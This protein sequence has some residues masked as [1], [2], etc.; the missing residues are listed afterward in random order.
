MRFTDF[1]YLPNIF[2]MASDA[3]DGLKTALAG[4]IKELPADEATIKTLREIE[5]LL[6]D[7]NAG[8]R[9]GLIKKDLK[10][11][12]DPAVHKAQQILARFIVSIDGTPEQRNELFDLWRKDQLV[13]KEQL[14]S[15]DRV[16][17]A[18][19]FNGYGPNPVITELVDNLMRIMT[20]GHGKGE[21]ALSVLSKSINK[22]VGSKGD[23]VLTWKGRQYQ[24]E[25]KTSDIGDS[26]VNPE[27]GEEKK[28]SLSSAR[29]GD[30]EVTVADG[31]HAAALELNDFVSA[32]GQYK[33]RKGYKLSGIGGYGVN[34]NKA[35]D[36]VTNCTP[37][38]KT[39]FMAMA[40]KC[41]SL[42]FGKFPTDKPVR[43]E[44]KIRLKKN[45]N[46]ILG[47]IEAGDNGGA[48]QAYSVANFNY[49]MAKKHDDGVLFISIPNGT[50]VWYNNAEDLEQ[51]GLRLHSDTISIS[52]TADV[53]RAVYPQMYVN[54]T[55][56]GANTAAKELKK[57]KF[58]KKTDADKFKQSM[59]DWVGRIARKRNITNSRLIITMGT[60]A[61]TL[62]MAG[63]ETAD[64]I[65]AL[66]DKYPQFKKPAPR[67]IQP[68]QT[69]PAENPEE[70]P[71]EAEPQPT[72]V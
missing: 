46:S 48:A 14:F 64:I 32:R 72:T 71:A 69:T 35:I 38:E 28:G 20:N 29:F 68:V 61:Y 44:Y 58:T 11:I 40:R 42:I 4:K 13:N 47:A 36:F 9:V 21:F 45:I 54:P 33:T 70:V 2:E 31:Y 6:R 49:Y 18:E 67:Q 3:L 7:T 15:G 66:E 41:I 43:S 63:Y 55:T 51:K 5:D 26:T 62:R 22:P 12:E 25:V 65:S 27:T 39:K 59:I 24:V 34:L 57:L 8:G 17:F 19:V 50:F 37:E 1:K 23:L 60:F 16:G 30:Q 52:A 10:S 56:F 53:G